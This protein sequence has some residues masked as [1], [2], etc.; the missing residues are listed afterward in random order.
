MTKDGVA[1]Q[2][3]DGKF[4]EMLFKAEEMDLEE[5]NTIMICH[6]CGK[7]RR[8]I[9]QEPPSGSCKWV[10]S[11]NTDMRFNKCTIPQER[12][13]WKQ[14]MGPMPVLNNPILKHVVGVVN[15]KTRRTALVLD[16]LPVQII[17]ATDL[18]CEDAINKLKDDISGESQTTDKNKIVHQNGSRKK[19]A[20]TNKGKSCVGG[21]KLADQN[22]ATDEPLPNCNRNNA[23]AKSNDKGNDTNIQKGERSTKNPVT[24]PG[25][26]SIPSS[27]EEISSDSDENFIK[28]LDRFKAGQISLKELK[29]KMSSVD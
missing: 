20:K 14:R 11:M 25:N 3:V 17:Q 18:C 22:M 27:E 2:V 8:L 4:S 23:E 5:V 15:T 10:C 9:D 21:I 16:Y 28:L 7:E 24:A 29:Q 6:D 12:K 1:I 19:K 13:L 26:I